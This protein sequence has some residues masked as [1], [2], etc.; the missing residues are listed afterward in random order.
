MSIMVPRY[1]ELFW[2]DWFKG[3]KLSMVYLTKSV[4]DTEIIS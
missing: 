3:I 4:S 1:V 2:V